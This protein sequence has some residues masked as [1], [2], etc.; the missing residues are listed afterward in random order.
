MARVRSGRIAAVLAAVTVLA[1]AAAAAELPTHSFR[2]PFKS[3][4][5]SFGNRKIDQWNV[6]G[7]S[8]L[9]ENFLRLTPDRASK[10]GYAWNYALM[11]EDHFT[12]TIYFR[13]SGQGQTLFGDGFAVWFTN[14]GRYQEGS[15][16]GFTDTF[17]GIGIVFDTF[18]NTESGHFHKDVAVVVNDGSGPLKLDSGVE[19]AGCDGD[20]RYHEKRDDFNVHIRSSA[21]I[22]FNKGKLSIRLDARGTGEYKE[23]VTDYEIPIPGD[24][25]YKTSYLGLTASTG[26]L[27]DNHDII[28]FVTAQ[29]NEQS[30]EGLEISV[31][32]VASGNDQVDAAIKTALGKVDL[33]MDSKMQD[34]RH[35]IEHDLAA[36]QDSLQNTIKKMQEKE[37]E[38]LERIEALEARMSERLSSKVGDAVEGRLKALEGKFSESLDARM[39]ENL[40]R[41]LPGLTDRVKADVGAELGNNGGGGG[42]GWVIPFIILLLIV[43]GM[44]GFG[45]NKYRD[46]KKSHLL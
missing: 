16:H 39:D 1:W 21:T 37:Q 8:V 13:V 33:S 28:A 2:P 6:G 18:R 7:S 22:T 23:C 42:G 14:S 29:G 44:A 19:P 3:Y 38:N 27:A 30:P 25:W 5:S 10:R 4:D 9:N 15:M 24:D 32:A 20:F 41:Q 34:F 36:I 46:F 40:K 45:Y 31:P 26:Q 12:S 17:R 43:L 11:H 35:E